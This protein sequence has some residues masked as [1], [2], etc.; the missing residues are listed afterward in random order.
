MDFCVVC[1]AA[2]PN[3]PSV[4]SWYCGDHLT[5][6]PT[7][8]EVPQKASQDSASQ[9]GS[10]TKVGQGT[11]NEEQGLAKKGISSSHKDSNTEDS[12]SP[13]SNE[14]ELPEVEGLLEDHAAGS[15][16]RSRLSCHPCR[17]MRRS[18]CG[19]SRSS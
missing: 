11:R 16:S 5:L 10:S 17:T 13:D 3:V 9:A 8:Q 19:W 14:D 12:N 1:R 15:W 18:L 4:E 2:N 6:E 7:L